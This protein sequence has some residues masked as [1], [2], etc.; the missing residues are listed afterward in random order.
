MKLIKYLTVTITLIA[1]AAC[2]GGGGSPGT[3]STGSQSPTPSTTVTVAQP[4]T[5]ELLAEKNALP[6]GTAPIQITA[7]VKDGNNV[8]MA[9]QTVTF[10]ANSGNLTLP[11]GVATGGVANVAL[12][13]ANGV[14]IALLSTGSNLANRDITISAKSSAALSNLVIPVTGTRIQATGLGSVKLSETATYTV[15]LTDSAGVAIANQRVSLSSNL[16]NSFSNSGSSVTDAGGV[17]SFI[18]TANVGGTDTLTASGLGADGTLTVAVNNVDFVAVF[19]EVNTKVTTNAIQALVVRYRVDGQ[20]VA[21]RVVTFS[22]TRGELSSNQATT[23]ENGQATVN[24]RSSSAGPA[25]VVARIDGVGQTS[26]PLQFVATQPSSI[27]VQANPGSVRPNLSGSTANQ[28]SLEAIVRDSTGNAVADSQVNFTIIQDA[29]NGALAQSSALTDINGRASVQ[30]IPGANSS[31]SNG[32]VIRA[33]VSSSI[34]VV[35]TTAL[36]VN[37][38]SL[39]ISIAFG[40]VISNLD[41]TTYRKPFSVYVTDANGVAVGNKNV[42]LRVIP[43]VYRKGFLTFTPGKPETATSLATQGGWGYSAPPTQCPNEDTNLNGTVDPNEDINRSGRLEPGNSV[44]ASPG[45]L[46]TDANGF[47]KFDLLYGEQYAFWLDVRLEA[48]AT[49][50]GTESVSSIIYSLEVLASDVS[51]ATISPAAQFSPYG[52]F[53]SCTN[54]N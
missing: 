49:V 50:G 47:A 8:G 41:E 20:P 17:A 36:T 52:T 33:V 35:G 53:Q 23:D 45:V 28:A 22:S 46:V 13:N 19:P 16:R 40:N 34:N 2:G 1:L 9:G 30:Y 39:F 5:I 21:N 48:R 42:T 27:A 25:S 12:T 38:E 26:L 44:V 29:S 4:A 7:V 51:S 6:S 54:P 24:I 32:V 15:K 18:Y 10:S 3:V 11:Q 31:P 37:G 43:T 14:A